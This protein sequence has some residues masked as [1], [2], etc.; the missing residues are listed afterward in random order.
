VIGELAASLALV[1]FGSRLSAR[2]LLQELDAGRLDACL[3]SPAA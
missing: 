3:R 2:E 1:P